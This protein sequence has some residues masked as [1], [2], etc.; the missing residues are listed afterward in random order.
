MRGE[1]ARRG[2]GHRCRVRFIPACAGNTW[3]CITCLRPAMVHPRMRGEHVAL[4][5]VPAAGYGSSPHARGTRFAGIFVARGNAVHPRMRGEHGSCRGP[6][7]S[8]VRFIPAC[9]GNTASGRFPHISSAVHPRMR[10]EH[11]NTSPTHAAASGS[12]PHARG[13]LY[14][15]NSKTIIE[16]FIPACAGNT[17]FATPSMAVS[18][19]HPR[20]RGEH[21]RWA[22]AD[23]RAVGSSPHA[24]GTPGGNWHFRGAHRFIPA[25][26]G[27]TS[28]QGEGRGKGAVHPRMRGEHTGHSGRLTSSAGSS[29]HARGTLTR[30]CTVS[31]MS[32]FIP[33][34]AGNT[35][36]RRAACWGQLVHPRMRGEHSMPGPCSMACTG[37]SPHAR[38]TRAPIRG[39]LGSCRF[40]PACAG[41]TAGPC[42]RW[43]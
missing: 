5:Y 7:I 38:G 11:R 13:T 22:G 40:I 34:C 26:A 14:H 43:V 25:C 18:M 35:A 41:N 37:S 3:R 19:V 32:W 4:H 6:R 27:N 30:T 21:A 17:C 15:D 8:R 9:A 29:P 24:R 10:G 23:V 36:D 42:C 12:S 31:V 28:V 16:R 1:H 33:A 20:M 2:H 39:F